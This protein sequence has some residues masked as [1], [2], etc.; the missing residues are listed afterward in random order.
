MNL[1]G[2]CCRR[3]TYADKPSDQRSAQL[4]G[5]LPKHE[6]AFHQRYLIFD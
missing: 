2:R 5:F 4:L 6:I 1:N 3:A